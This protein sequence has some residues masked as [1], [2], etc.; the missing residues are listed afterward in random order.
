MGDRLLAINGHSLQGRNV[1]DAVELMKA[2]G[3]SIA[4]KIARYLWF[5]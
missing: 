5:I 3:D 2:A 4:L 1:N